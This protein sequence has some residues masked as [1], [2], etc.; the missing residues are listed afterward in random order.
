MA[1]TSSALGI[2]VSKSTLDV[3]MWQGDAQSRREIQ[4]KHLWRSRFANNKAGITKLLHELDKRAGKHTPV[5]ACM[6]ATGR[7]HALAAEMLY[8]AGHT[9]SVVNPAQVKHF[10]EEGLVRNKNDA[11]D[12]VL[13]MTYCA[14]KQP[15]AWM[16]PAPEIKLLQAFYARYDDLVEMRTQEINRLK[17]GDQPAVLKASLQDSVAH[18]NKQIEQI[19]QWINTH[20]NQHPQLRERSRLLESID[21]IAHLTAGR[22]IA[23]RIDQ[24]ESPSKLAAYAGVTPQNDTSGTLYKPARMCRTGHMTLRTALYMPALSSLRHNVVIKRLAARLK[25]RGLKGKQIV[26]AAMHKLLHLAWGVLKTKTPFDPNWASTQATTGS[27]M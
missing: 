4:D 5:H 13:L 12:A 9:V 1:Q 20:I 25:K 26:V 6:E 17:A 21:G 11:L 18:L 8:A 27:P 10:R 2:D 15:R 23:F 22:L 7:Y 19:E 16:P 14:Q 24:F 3:A